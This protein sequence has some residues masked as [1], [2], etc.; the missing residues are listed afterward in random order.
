M[1][2]GSRAGL[3]KIAETTPAYALALALTHQPQFWR[4][5]ASI[6]AEERTAADL[7]SL[8]LRR[9]LSGR[10]ELLEL[11][12]TTA[13]EAESDGRAKMKLLNIAPVAYAVEGVPGP[14][15]PQRSLRVDAQETLMIGA[16]RVARRGAGRCIAH[17]C[18]FRD[19][20]EH[21][22]YRKQCPVHRPGAPLSKYAIDYCAVCE[23]KIR[24]ARE[25]DEAERS[26][27]DGAIAAVL[28]GESRP[29]RRR[30][31]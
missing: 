12:L 15:A 20:H 21:N 31:A 7:A 8:Y 22:C 3:S 9:P 14:T 26:L 18:G 28:G 6:R 10:L 4:H 27:F 5:V 25:T 23:P 1:A 29:A 13:A 24:K 19:C 11:Y 2:E 30:A 17:D 16:L